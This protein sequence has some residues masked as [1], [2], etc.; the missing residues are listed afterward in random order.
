MYMTS[1]PAHSMPL[2]LPDYGLSLSP[3][4]PLPSQHR[5]ISVYRLG[6]MPIQ[7]CVQSVRAPRGKAGARLNAHTELRAR[8]QRSAR[9][10]IYRNRPIQHAAGQRQAPAELGLESADVRRDRCTHTALATRSGV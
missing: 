10:M 5:P 3:S 7:C 8:R 9:E 6:E 2:S 4:L 1:I